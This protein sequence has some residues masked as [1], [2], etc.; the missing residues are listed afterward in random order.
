MTQ[1]KKT[2]LANGKEK[3]ARVTMVTADKI[4]FKAK[5]ITRDQDIT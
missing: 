3:Q 5:T 1:Q 4:D 2:F